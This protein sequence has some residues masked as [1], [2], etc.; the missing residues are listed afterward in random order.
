M[1]TDLTNCKTGKHK[2]KVIYEGHA[3]TLSTEVVRWCVK[4]GS[5]VVDLDYDGRTNPGQIMK[6]RSPLIAT[7]Q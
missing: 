4:C 1:A 5:V 7:D 6:M 2:L 3:D